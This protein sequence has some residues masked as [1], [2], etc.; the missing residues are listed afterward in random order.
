MKV[1][2]TVSPEIIGLFFLLVSSV[3]SVSLTG[4]EDFW[5]AVAT[6]ITLF[7]IMFIRQ[8]LS[9]AAPEEDKKPL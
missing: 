1:L 5:I 3:L 9:E 7:L 8:N 4:V 2:S 6:A